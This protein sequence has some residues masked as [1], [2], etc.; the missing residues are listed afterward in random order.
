MWD[1]AGNII[2]TTVSSGNKYAPGGP[3][4]GL[5]GI[6]LFLGMN[7]K[8]RSCDGWRGGRAAPRVAF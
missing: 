2:L 7:K 8:Q 6:I 1:G 5:K 4:S 3:T